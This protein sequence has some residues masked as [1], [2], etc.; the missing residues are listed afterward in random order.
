MYNKKR[1]KIKRAKEAFLKRSTMSVVCTISTSWRNVVLIHT[2][3]VFRQHD[4]GHEV[5]QLLF[6]RLQPSGPQPVQIQKVRN[7]YGHVC[8]GTR[9][10]LNPTEE[11]DDFIFNTLH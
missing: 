5:R 2:S 9:Q 7:I 4:W 8:K 11:Y 6:T 10:K 3:G 1:G